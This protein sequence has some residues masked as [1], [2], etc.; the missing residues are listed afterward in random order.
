M[1][2]FIVPFQ[3]YLKGIYTSENIQEGSGDAGQRSPVFKPAQADTVQQQIT[4]HEVP[5]APTWL[6]DLNPHFI[7]F[8]STERMT[9]V[10]VLVKC[11]L[12]RCWIALF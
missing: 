11:H 8:T 12:R 10:V 6:Q 2:R 3:T 7:L 5:Q 4:E 1:T 9:C